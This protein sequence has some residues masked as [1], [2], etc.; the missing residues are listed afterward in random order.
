MRSLYETLLRLYPASFRAEYGREMTRAYQD[1]VRN[2][3]RF[4]AFLAALFDVVPNAFLAHGRIF[5]QD[6][7]YALRTLNRSRGFA[8]TVLF[9]SKYVVAAKMSSWSARFASTLKPASS[10]L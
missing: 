3:G 7:R 9:R 2:R 8:A 10:T 4:G 5:R 6:F 1:S